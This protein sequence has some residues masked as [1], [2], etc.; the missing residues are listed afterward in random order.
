MKTKPKRLRELLGSDGIV[1][2]PAVYDCIGAM[3]AVESGF[4]MLF[5]SG[6]GMSAALLGKPDIGLLTASEIIEQSRRIARAV[7][8]P[9]IADLDTGYGG[10]LN[11]VRCVSDA[12]DG[13][14]A[15]VILEDQTWPKRCGHFDG[16]Q[17]VTLEEHAAKIRAAVRARGDSGL[18]IVARTDARA[19]EGLESAIVR[20][21]AYLQAGADVL[22]IEAPESIEELRKIGEEFP[23]DYLFANPLEGG[24][25]P[26][27]PVGELQQLGFNLCAFAVSELIARVSAV[28]S[29]YKGIQDKGVAVTSEGEGLSYLKDLLKFDECRSLADELQEDVG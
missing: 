5:T 9:I 21:R 15:G 24:K 16:K 8:L 25:T 27:L 28:R 14:L 17:V 10:V 7:D 20:G 23:S 13:G 26:C 4:E 19:V 11:V 3:L 22:F 1:Y 12:V 29:T 6:F 18:V 2:G